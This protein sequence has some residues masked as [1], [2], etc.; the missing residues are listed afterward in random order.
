[1]KKERRTD[2]GY[3]RSRP[4]KC[5]T[6]WKGQVPKPHGGRLQKRHI[7]ETGR[8]W[9]WGLWLAENGHKGFGEMMQCSQTGLWRWLCTWGQLLKTLAFVE[10]K[11]CL[12]EAVEK[13][14]NA[15]SLA[16]PGPADLGSG[17][18]GQVFRALAQ[19]LRITTFEDPR[20]RAGG[21]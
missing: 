3:H 11:V 20:P 5:F 12:S 4:Q 16:A 7:S 18:P 15:G 21:V 2:A 1:M 9:E 8:R 13:L 19:S 10:C 17:G 6:S 14:R